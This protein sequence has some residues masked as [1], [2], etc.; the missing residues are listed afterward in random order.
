MEEKDYRKKVNE[1]FE[2]IVK[3]FDE[4]DPDVVEAELS[5]G[6]LTLTSRAKSKTVLSAQPSVRQI[7]LAAA[8][9]GIAAHF[10]WDAAS[11]TW[12]DDKGKGY[13][14]FAFLSDVVHRAADLRVSF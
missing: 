1:A 9:Q 11:G 7:W 5:Q 8:A 6:A 12:R 2:R 4:I 13:E 10:N 14:L 3:A